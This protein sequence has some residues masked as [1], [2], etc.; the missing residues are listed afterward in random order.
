MRTTWTALA[1]A[2]ALIPLSAAT[3]GAQQR[4]ATAEMMDPNGNVIGTVELTE[5]PNYGV[6]LRVQM[7]GLEPGAHALHIHETGR[8]EAPSFDSAGGHY[9]PR[10]RMHGILHP[11]GK[12]AGDLANL[13][14]PAGGAVSTERLAHRVTLVP[15]AT[16]TL[17]DDDGSA[18]VVHA[19][20]DDYESQ[21]AGGGGPKV[22][23]GV[24][25]R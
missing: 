6:L 12:H 8:C 22:A 5:T 1:L 9:A 20:A 4:T 15:D 13:H 25:R 23:C 16:G 2:A 14:V 24:I 10:G 19:T 21:P 18:I 3:A 17:F 11:H 7:E